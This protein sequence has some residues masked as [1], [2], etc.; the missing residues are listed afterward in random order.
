MSNVIIFDPDDSNVPG[1]V[2]Y[3]LLSVHTPSYIDN[4]NALINPDV[5]SL[6]LVPQKHWKESSGSVVEMSQAEKD[7]IDIPD[8]DTQKQTKYNAIDQ[9]TGVL[10]SGGFEY[11]SITFS[12]SLNAQTNWSAIKNNESEFT[13]PLEISTKLNYK[14]SLAQ[15]DVSDFW[16]AGKDF[17]KEHLDSGRGLKVSVNDATTQTELDAVVDER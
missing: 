12:A 5:S 8:L 15:A 11:D 2:T 4:S 13:F 9:K 6:S 3:Y 7:A 16:I 14:Y 1:R 17:I 10:I